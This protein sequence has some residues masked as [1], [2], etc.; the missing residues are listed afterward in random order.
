MKRCSHG[1]ALAPT[2]ASITTASS[3]SRKTTHGANV[4]VRLWRRIGIDSIA[5]VHTADRRSLWTE[6]LAVASL[7]SALTL[8]LAYPLSVHPATRVLPQ[9]ADK[10]LNLW[11]FGWDV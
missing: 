5:R 7:Y 9:G 1:V 10:E 3:G 11:I 6:G 2:R 4:A 8:I